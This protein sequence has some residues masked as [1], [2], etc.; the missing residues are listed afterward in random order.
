[1]H[2][3]AHMLVGACV[4]QL[5]S[6]P[7]GAVLGGLLSH[8]V[9]DAIPHTEGE[10]FAEGPRPGFGLDLVEAGLEFL[11]GV[12]MLGWVLSNCT[13][14]R[15]GPMLLG[16]LA[17]LIPDAIDTPMMMFFGKTVVHPAALHW[18]VRR[19]H[20]FWGILTQVLVAAGAAALLW[21]WA[22][23]G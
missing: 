19:R 8:F 13:A 10:T 17:A 5:A 23:C 20:A 12:A 3:V 11:V 2:P 1:M 6:S 7:Q 15:T 9:L 4:G 14:T 22:G 21:R 16:T 18:T